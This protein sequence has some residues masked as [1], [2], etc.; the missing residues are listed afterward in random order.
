MCSRNYEDKRS[1]V[2][3]VK[4]NT[5]K[6]SAEKVTV[7]GG[8]EAT[9]FRVGFGDPAQNDAIVQDADARFKE[10]FSETEKP[11]DIDGAMKPARN[12]ELA[13]VNGPASV[14]AALVIGHNIAHRFGAVAG[15]D[16]KIP[17]DKKYVIC[18]THTPKYKLG[19]LVG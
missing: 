4:M 15:F 2:V 18:I 1:L 16:P 8:T 7:N 9:L 14:C 12:G 19:D 3:F 11:E 17:G 13:L 6:V 5:Y 10:I